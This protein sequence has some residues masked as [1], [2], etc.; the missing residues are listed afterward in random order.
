[1][2]T[3]LLRRVRRLFAHDLAPVHV[4]RH[5]MRQWCISMRTLGSNHTLATPVKRKPVFLGEVA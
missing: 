4:Q 5:N 1:M 3:T 2:N